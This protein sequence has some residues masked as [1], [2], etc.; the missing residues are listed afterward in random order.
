[1]SNPYETLS[2]G[3]F[4]YFLDAEPGDDAAIVRAS[5]GRA[6]SAQRESVRGALRALLASEEISLA[7]LGTESN[8]WF[9]NE[10]EAREWIAGLLR[11]A[12][13]LAGASDGADEVVVKDSNGAVLNEGDSVIVIKDLKV[14]GGSSDLKRGT[15][16]KNVHLTGDRDTIECRVNGAT[17]VLRTEFLK[18]S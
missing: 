12:D 3:L 1:M 18:K 17:L 8:R 7:D 14:K 13:A 5:L 4:A 6:S 11:E 2:K 16:I 15:A 9:E 10:E